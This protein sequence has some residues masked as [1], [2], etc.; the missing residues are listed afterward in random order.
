MKCALADSRP[1]TLTGVGGSGKSRLAIQVATD[2]LNE[3]SDG[4]WL[5]ELAP[6]SEPERVPSAVASAL[7]IPE[8]PHRPTGAGREPA[9]HLRSRNLLLVVDNCEHVLP[10][11]ADLLAGLLGSVP[12]LRVLATSREELRGA[13]RKCHPGALT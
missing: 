2:L 10:A 9:D 7:A 12:G 11:C 13:R 4:A 5:V 8:D 3:Y 6:L 1:V